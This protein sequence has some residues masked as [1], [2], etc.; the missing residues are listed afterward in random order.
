MRIWFQKHAVQGRSIL[1]DKLYAEHLSAVAGAATTVEVHTLPS[2]TYTDVLPEQL[3]GY[4]EIGQLIGDYFARSAVAAERDGCDAW[5][6]GAGQDPGLAAAR[7]RTGNGIST[8]GGTFQRP[9][10]RGG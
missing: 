2:E 1:L 8:S 5:I 9:V 6:S 10:L 3:V 4:G 7:T